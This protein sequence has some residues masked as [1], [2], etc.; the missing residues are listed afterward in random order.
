MD[1]DNVLDF[2]LESAI[3]E[4][5]AIK[6]ESSEGFN[7]R[8]NG[9][10]N[11]FHELK[12]GYILIEKEKLVKKFL[13]INYSKFAPH[14]VD[15]VDFLYE[16]MYNK[17]LLTHLREGGYDIRID[18]KRKIERAIEIGYL[19]KEE[20]LDSEKVRVENLRL[21]KEGKFSTA[22][23]LKFHDYIEREL[24]KKSV[25]DLN[26]GWKPKK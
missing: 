3:S 24:R 9:L 25:K 8:I 6:K 12:R 17:A 4:L 21:K 13:N 11:I 19:T 14:L 18:R 26:Y 10:T 22:D 1:K 15:K 7:E 20:F 23:N 16:K 5:K 2:S